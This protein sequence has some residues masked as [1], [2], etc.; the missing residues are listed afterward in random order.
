MFTGA[1][2]TI[3]GVLSAAWSSMSG[4]AESV[5]NGI[6][7]F[8]STVLSGIQTGFSNA[9]AG[10]KISV[11]RAAIRGVG[12]CQVHRQH[13]LRQGHRSRCQRGR[14][15][16]RPETVR[17]VVR[18]RRPGH[19]GTGPTADDVL[20]RVSK[21]ETIVSAAHSQQLA[22]F[23]EALG[24]PGYA[25]RGTPAGGRGGTLGAG[26]PT[27]SPNIIGDIGKALADL[28]GDALGAAAKAVLTRCWPPCPVVG[29]SSART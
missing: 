23:F 13:G 4:T 2:G 5:W 19:R 1:V 15:P 11:V 29:R 27:G 22:P 12:P 9:V 10:I 24:V 21:G 20:A 6:K 16:D 18:G 26:N 3:K 14:F 8:F 28:T 25:G 7:G 17:G